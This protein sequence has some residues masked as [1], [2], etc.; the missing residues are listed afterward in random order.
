MVKG[1]AELKLLVLFTSL[2]SSFK[3]VEEL[4]VF[5]SIYSGSNDNNT[6]KQ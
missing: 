3:R 1:I 4:K 6:S 5:K 2:E